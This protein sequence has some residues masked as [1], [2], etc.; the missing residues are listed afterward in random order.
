TC[1]L[2]RPDHPW[3]RSARRVLRDCVT[4]SRART[5]F[6][7][8]RDSRP[9]GRCAVSVFSEACIVFT[10]LIEEVG[11]IESIDKTDA[12]VELRIAST[13]TGV[14]PG[15]SIAVSGPW[16]TVTTCGQEA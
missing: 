15:E 6:R 3:R 12:G 2:S 1:N 11:V 7:A 13:F 5:T 4:G 16:L 14:E 10:G 8:A 9:W